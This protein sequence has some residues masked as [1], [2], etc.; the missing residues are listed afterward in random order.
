M[1]DVTIHTPTRLHFGKRSLQKAARIVSALGHKRLLLVTGRGSCH[2]SGA[3][4]TLAQGLEKHAIAWQE[5]AGMPPN[6]AM[7]HVYSVCDAART[8]QPQ[9]L[10][11]LGGGSVLDATKAAAASLA[12]NTPPWELF[13][14]GKDVRQALPLYAAPTLAGSGSECNGEAIARGGEPPE[15]R[16]L[17]GPALFPLAAFV[18][19]ALQTK[20]TWEQTRPG[21][22]DMF[23]HVMERYV[24]GREARTASALA[25]TLMRNMLETAAAVRKEPHSTALRAEL[26]WSAIMAQS[27]LLAGSFAPGDW[28]VHVLAHSVVAVAPRLSHGEVVAALLPNWLELVEELRP[29]LLDPWAKEVLAR[30]DGA[31]GVAGL[32]EVLQQWGCAPGLE[33]LGLQAS[34]LDAAA[35]LAQADGERHGGLGRAVPLQE[36]IKQLF[37]MSF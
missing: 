11:A 7:E 20:L 33:A 29:G 18:D 21:V 16:G 19:P 3:F 27:G 35:H 12:C 10:F 37:A 23:S 25:E 28:T 2:D 22:A 30:S 9:A 31:A 1:R 24:P 8:F 17:R 13:L 14:A 26:C 4:D 15:I 5:C 36:R 6:P 32:R 34:E